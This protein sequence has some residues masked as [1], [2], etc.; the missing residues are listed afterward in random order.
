MQG[1]VMEI[2]VKIKSTDYWFKVVDFLQQNWAIIEEIKGGY[3]VYFFGDTAGIFDQLDFESIS[4]AKIVLNR[5]GFGRYEADKGA[6]EFIVKPK[7][8]FYMRAHPSGAIYSSGRYW[9]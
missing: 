8:L 3:T 7:P 1:G 2:T 4:E 9:L 6:Q 5:N